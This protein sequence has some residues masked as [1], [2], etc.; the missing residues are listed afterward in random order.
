MALMDATFSFLVPLR[1]EHR[2]SE[3]AARQTADLLVV[4]SVYASPG[5]PPVG[6]VEEAQVVREGERFLVEGRATI[7]DRAAVLAM[8]SADE[9]TLG[10]RATFEPGD[11]DVGIKSVSKACLEVVKP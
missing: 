6:E 2:L 10:L 1:E 5:G 8:V 11:A 3:L 4:A 7:D 9:Y